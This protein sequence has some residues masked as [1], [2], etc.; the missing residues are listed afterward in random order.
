MQIRFG[1][2]LIGTLLAL[3]LSICETGAST[4]NWPQ[5]RGPNGSGVAPKGRPPIKIGPTNNV[6]WCIRV[7]WSPSSPCVWGDRIFLTTFESGELQTHCY[8]ARTGDLF[9]S[10]GIKPRKLEVFHS[11]DG[12]PAASTPVTDGKRVVSY[13]GS[14]GLVCYDFKG[15]ELWRFP[16]SVAMSGGSYGSGTSPIIVGKR[17][18]LSRDQD[19][20]SSLLAVDLTTGK[21]LWET[22]RPDAVGS[23][24]T[25]I[26]WRIKGVDEVVVPGASRLKGYDVK[27]GEERWFV[28]GL[29]SFDCTTPVEGAGMVF[30]AGWTPGKNDSPWGTWESFLEKNDK[31]HDGEIALEE[32]PEAVRD[33]IRG[34][35]SDRDGKITKS[36]W[37]KMQARLAKAQNLMVAVRPGGRGDI[38][39]TH[40]AWKAT[41]GLP[42]VASPLFYDGRVYLI[43]DGGMFSSFDA[44][45]GRTFYLQERV[46]EAETYYASPVA[47]DGRIYLASLPGKLI[48]IK[49]GGDKPEILHQANFGERILATPA[50]AGDRL[51]LRTQ[52][53]LYAY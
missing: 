51:Y 37:D 25:P 3:T 46:G 36:D 24:G 9:W 13:F 14:V 15:K 30:F 28:G 17:V 41:R 11:T 23:F 19:I 22:P 2:S 21:M 48:V 18:I 8:A 45:T 53:Q 12:S 49:A 44:K 43:R 4:L 34:M 40:V 6:R 35:D 47:A 20:G 50:L 10:R 39:E 42:Y 1:I 32:F 31:N 26:H 33:Y 38:T 16:L 7:P 5:F 52:K 27:T 29:V